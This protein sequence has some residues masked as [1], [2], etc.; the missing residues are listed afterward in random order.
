MKTKLVLSSLL[1]VFSLQAFAQDVTIIQSNATDNTQS[2]S[3]SKKTHKPR[4]WIGPKFGTDI[5]SGIPADFEDVTDR[6]KQQW[7]AGVMMQFGRTLY[8]QPEAYYAVTNT[9]D[10]SGAIT[11]SQQSIK[12]P[13][14]LG[15]RF[16]NLG[17]FS[18]HIMGGPSWTLPMGSDNTIDA[19]AKKMEWLVG[20]GIDVLGF[21]TA[22]IRYKY[23][24]DTPLSDQIAG[25]NVSDDDPTR[26]YTPLNVTIGLKLR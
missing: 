7:Q 22:D 3:S 23:L 12:V 1:L 14:M 6:L 21:I 20:A 10:G 19:S 26:P 5:V 24:T 16:L 25:F 15:L 4:F 11:S 9:L 13:V 2:Y 18:L 17:L 8:L